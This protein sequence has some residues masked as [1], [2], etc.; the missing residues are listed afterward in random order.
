MFI[1]CRRFPGKGELRLTGQLGEVMKESAT[2][3]WSWVRANAD[4]HG[5]D[6]EKIMASDLHIHLPQGAIKKDGPSAGV[7]LTVAV[8]SAL[9]GRTVRNDVAVTGEIDLRGHALPVGGIKEK[10]LAAH[11]AGISTVVLPERNRKDTIEIPAEVLADVRLEYIDKIDGALAIAL[12][13][14]PADADPEP[15]IP[16]PSAT[17]RPS[18]DRLPS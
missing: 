7:A 6:H 1:E 18:H 10:V 17:P 4:K 8:M 2:T 3:A 13:D 12:G 11:R 15:A 16:P 5:L 9:T 14:V